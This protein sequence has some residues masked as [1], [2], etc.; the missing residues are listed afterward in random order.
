MTAPKSTLHETHH[1][2]EIRHRPW[3]RRNPWR[4]QVPNPRSHALWCDI[5]SPQAARALIDRSLLLLK[6]ERKG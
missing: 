2:Y 5:A 6:L 1:G 3:R 4:C